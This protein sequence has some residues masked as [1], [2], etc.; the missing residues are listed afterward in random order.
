MYIH[1]L[2]H[3]QFLSMSYCSRVNTLF[4]FQAELI[5]WHIAVSLQRNDRAGATPLTWVSSVSYLS[6]VS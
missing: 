6:P 4:F 3:T 2:T 5:S 1:T